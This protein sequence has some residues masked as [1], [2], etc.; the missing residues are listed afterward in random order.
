MTVQDALYSIMD[1]LM[2]VEDNVIS[3]ANEYG[4]PSTLR[5]YRCECDESYAHISVESKPTIEV[6]KMCVLIEGRKDGVFILET[7]EIV[8]CV[9]NGVLVYRDSACVECEKC[10]GGKEGGIVVR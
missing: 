4:L 1:N 6:L 8:E 3:V 9:S 10:G 7:G 5:V 2:V